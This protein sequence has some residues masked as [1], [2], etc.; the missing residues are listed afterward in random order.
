MLTEDL[1]PEQNEAPGRHTKGPVTSEKV[2][3]QIELLRTGRAHWHE[4][5]RPVEMGN[6]VTVDLKLTVEGDKLSDLTNNPFEM[7]AERH[8]MFSGMDEQLLGMTVGESKTFTTTIPQ[9]YTNAKLAGKAGQY[10]VTLHKIEE[11]HVLARDDASAMQV[12]NGHKTLADFS[13]RLK[14]K[15]KALV[16]EIVGGT[17]IVSGLIWIGVV[18]LWYVASDQTKFLGLL[19]TSIIGLLAAIGALWPSFKD[20]RDYLKNRHVNRGPLFYK[21]VIITNI[22]VPLL[23]VVLVLV[24]FDPY[25]HLGWQVLSSPFNS[26]N[27]YYWHDELS[28]SKTASGICMFDPKD[29]AYHVTATK[30]VNYYCVATATDYSDFIYEVQM[31]FIKGD[32]G[33]IVFRADEASDND[34]TFNICQDQTYCLLRFIGPF[35]SGKNH[36]LIGCNPQRGNL[37]LLL[38]GNDGRTKPITL[39][40][41][42]RGEKFVLFV[43]HQVLDEGFDF[44]DQELKEG[45][46]GVDAGDV[47][48]PTE[49][50]F[51]NATVWTLNGS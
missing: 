31:K 49:V 48:H 14:L 33:G 40:V 20:I 41:E 50:A 30:H 5:E 8:G 43:N 44:S 27:D 51:S 34:Y 36:Y 22:V 18:L 25:T 19:A 12:S 38:Q 37:P 32:C 9:D 29:G 11:K 45:E 42:V 47:N 2:D 21:A 24:R 26:T 28:T 6:R 23:C 17:V 4:V 15:Q 35:S 16:I 39:A 46:I 7:M 10:E 1:K 3:R 13:A